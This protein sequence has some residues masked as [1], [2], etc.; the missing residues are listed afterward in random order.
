M[1]F[2]ESAVNACPEEE[3]RRSVRGRAV[4]HCQQNITRASCGEPQTAKEDVCNA[5][6]EADEGSGNVSNARSLKKS[7]STI[8]G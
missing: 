4:W 7:A 3:R 2:E 8:Y 6:R 5:W 1:A